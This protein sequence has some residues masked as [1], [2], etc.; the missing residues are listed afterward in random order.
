MCDVR[1]DK[2]VLAASGS[3]ACGERSATSN[4]SSVSSIVPLQNH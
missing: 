2:D 4:R 3:G 1:A